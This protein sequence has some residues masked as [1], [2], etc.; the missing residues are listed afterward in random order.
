MIDIRKQ[1]AGC[2]YL[3]YESEDDTTNIVCRHG[4]IYADGEHLFAALYNGTRSQILR[5]R[6]LGEPIMDGDFG[7]LTIRFEPRQ[8]PAVA[9]VMKPRQRDLA[10]RQVA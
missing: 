10:A 8:F 4:H 9:R 3:I 6:K 1:F 2:G 7:E 5:L